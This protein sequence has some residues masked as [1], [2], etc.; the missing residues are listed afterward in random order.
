V[1]DGNQKYH[2]SKDKDKWTAHAHP[3]KEGYTKPFTDAS[4]SK[5]EKGRK[6]EKCTYCHKGFHSESAC[7]QKKIDL[8]SQ[9]LQKNNL[10]DRIPEGSKKKN[11]E[12]LNS[13]KGNS[14][15]A[16]IAINS[17]P[18]AWIVDSG[19]SHHMAASKEIY[20]SL[21]ACKCPPILMGDNSSIEVTNKGRIELTNGSFENVL[22]VPKHFVNLLSVYQMTNYNIG[23]KFIFTPNS[24]DIYDI[25]TN[26][27][28]ATSEVN[29]QSR[30]YTFS[31]FIEPDSSLLLTHADE[32][33]RIW[34]KRFENL[35]FRYMQHLS[36]HILVDGL[37][38][39][40]F[41]KGV[42]EGCVLG[43]HIQEKF[44]KGK[45]Q[46]A[47][48]PLY[49]IHSDLM[50]PF[51]HPYISKSRFVLIFVDDLSRFTWIYFL[52]QKSKVFQH[53]KDFKALVETQSGKKIKVLRTNNGGEYVN[54]EIQN[55]FHE[56]GIQLQHTTPYTL[57]QNE[58]VEQ[59]NRSLKEMASCMLHAKSL[60]KRLWAEALNCETYIQNRS[61][62]RSVKDKT[63]YEAWSGLKLKVTH[64]CIF[65]SRAWARIP[66]EKRKA[67]DP[68]S[69]ECIFVGY[70]D[71]VKGYVLIDLSSD[72]LIFEHSV[73][74]EESVSHVPQ[75]P[76]ANTF[77]LPPVRDDENAHADSYSHES[78][79]SED[80]YDSDSESVQLDVESEHLDVVAEPEQ[81]PKWAQ[82]TLQDAGDLVGDLANTRRTRS[83]FEEPPIA[84]TATEPFLSK[85]IFFVQYSD[86]QS[87]GEAA[88]NPFWESSMHEEYNSLI[89]NQT[90]DLVPLPSGRKIVICRWVYM[91]KST[92]NG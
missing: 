83:D 22:H 45:S 84:L 13:K 81:R 9:I 23:K 75:Q 50:G 24:V 80:S 29:H 55:I 49:L 85:H 68:Q 58:V 56:A 10:G 69:T 61:P 7:M 1:N 35:N 76:H 3:K 39:I 73:Q 54:H 21:D 87:Y 25:Q 28:V 20:Y 60:P 27:R 12:D 40:H 34:H 63:P 43:K 26:S 5:G 82:T 6:G 78:S 38:N 66:S 53:L 88:G 31:K 57:Q 90:W 67:L 65:G 64:F 30:L 47:S 91:T 62:H 17:S 70:L 86:P 37:P 44:D 46:R 18:N 51:S 74:F 71:G 16:L 48:T 77:T 8:M 15:H 89:E 36:K 59:K 19:A 41:S 72:W 42:C 11:L 52:R 92:T 33:S 79:D 4:G 14:S 2:K 32:S